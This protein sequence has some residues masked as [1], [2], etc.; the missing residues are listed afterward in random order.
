MCPCCRGR[1]WPP[2]MSGEVSITVCLCTHNRPHY[3][4]ACLDGL[5]RQSVGADGFE[6]LVIDSAGAG[7]VPAQLAALVAGVVNAR[8]LRV[9]QA[10]VSAARNLGAQA[11]RG[12]YIAYIDDDAIPAPDWIACIRAAIAEHR[13]AVLAGRVL[14]LWERA[15][16]AWWPSGLRGVLSIIE[17]ERG[18]EFRGAALPAGL[19]PCAA[20]MTVHLPALREVGG[21]TA[22]L[23]RYGAALL[24][25][26]EVQ[27][28]WKLQACGHSVRYDPR[29]VVRHQI[30]AARMC[31]AWLLSRLYWQGASTVG[32]RRILRDPGSV[33]REL[34][35][36][37]AV[38][39]ML[40]PVALI[41]PRSERLI[42]LRWRFAYAAGFV[43]AAFG[44]RADRAARGRVSGRRVL[45]GS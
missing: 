33:W 25:D 10:G 8:L 19:V 3:A 5:R 43:R 7:A 6:I 22:G 1:P 32:T 39:V 34:P 23:G 2:R 18:G 26:E 4:A 41:P 16:P 14:P 21:F 27:F 12:E 40:A 28:A 9:A 36:R 29:P 20:N 11:A 37:L 30:Q 38:A 31:P 42:F 24:S 15:L 13:P 17:W 44:W 45:V 35:R